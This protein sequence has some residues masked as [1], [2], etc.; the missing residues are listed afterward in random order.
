MISCYLRLWNCCGVMFT[1][2][3]YRVCRD[4]RNYQQDTIL[5]SLE[6]FFSHQGPWVE[7]LY[8]LVGPWRWL[9]LWRARSRSTL[10]SFKKKHQTK[11]R[12]F[13]WRLVSTRQGGS[14]FSNQRCPRL[15]CWTSGNSSLSKWTLNTSENQ[16]IT[17]YGHQFHW[18][19][20]VGIKL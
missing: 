4:K 14:C 10:V 12:G 7:L 9:G 19:L 18:R 1:P 8:I 17:L 15:S 16:T 11:K 13:S 2:K 3:K 20:T 5:G 6:N